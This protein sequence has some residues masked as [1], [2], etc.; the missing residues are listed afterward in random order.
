MEV[1]QNKYSFK[2]GYNNVKKKDLCAVKKEIMAALKLGNAM[3]WSNRIN[4]K[5][6]PRINEVEII[7]AIF[8]KYGV[9]DVWGNYEEN[10]I[11]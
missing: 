8:R 10:S 7:E 5:V 11:N 3:T 9:T 4:G 6:I 1:M 2:N